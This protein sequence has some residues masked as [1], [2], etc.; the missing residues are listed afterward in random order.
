MT[1]QLEPMNPEAQAVLEAILAEDKEYLTPNEVAFL[2]A[3]AG[4][5]NDEQKKRFAEE[6][7]APAPKAEKKKK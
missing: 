7:K 3:R 5:L 4:Y 2:R 1:K 6:L